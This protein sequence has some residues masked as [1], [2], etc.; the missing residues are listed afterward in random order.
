M[1]TSWQVAANRLKRE[2]KTL[3]QSFLEEEKKKL[4]FPKH[5]DDPDRYRYLHSHASS[6]A[7]TRLIAKQRDMFNRFK[8]EAEQQ[9]YPKTAT[10]IEEEG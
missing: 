5:K 2:F 1:Q 7:R 4:D 3:F 9:G 10:Y 8:R 6:K